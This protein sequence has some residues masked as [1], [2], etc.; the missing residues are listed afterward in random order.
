M[1][2]PLVSVLISTYNSEK[3]ITGRIEDLIAQSIFKKIE[4]I[5]IDSGSQQYEGSI[6]K[7]FINRYSNIKYIRTDK[8][9]T[10]Y[11]A[12]NRGIKISSGTYITNANTDDRLRYDA[13]EI[14]SDTLEKDHRIGLVYAYQ[15]VTPVPDIPFD[16]NN[17][18]NKKIAPPF[19][20]LNLFFGYFIGSQPMW[21]ASLHFNDDVWFNEDYE[22]A[23]DY[24]FACRVA[25]KTRIQL[26]PKYLGTYFKATDNSNKEFLNLNKTRLESLSI[27]ILY[28][29]R[30]IASLSDAKQ[31]QLT[32]MVIHKL[33]FPAIFFKIIYKLYPTNMI[34]SK[35]QWIWLA[36]MIA[37]SKN[38]FAKALKYCEP[39]K[40]NSNAILIQYQI[41][42]LQEILH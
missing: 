39:F 23:G 35:M 22:V 36:S 18:K 34:Y 19:N 2:R 5:V 38:D 42:R 11:K 6:V 26:I 3:Y 8:R 27:Q 41:K 20:R 1:D 37:E 31:K 10:I 24:D 14:L 4:I 30:Y 33:L 17:S 32:R 16:K 21:R 12:W 40:K 9:E 7:S 29:K 28:A 25:E 15:Y 13:L